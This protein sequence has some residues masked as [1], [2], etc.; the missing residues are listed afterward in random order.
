MSRTRWAVALALTTVFGA[1]CS[2]GSGGPPSEIFRSTA[3]T[4]SP[5]DDLIDVPVTLGPTRQQLDALNDKCGRIP[6]IVRTGIEPGTLFVEVHGF[7]PDNTNPVTKC[8]TKLPFYRGTDN[9]LV[10]Q[11]PASAFLPG[12]PSAA[13]S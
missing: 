7:G 8:L 2:S 4:P 12:Q 6:G 3:P 9:G 10:E 11:V 5:G 13:P 1:G